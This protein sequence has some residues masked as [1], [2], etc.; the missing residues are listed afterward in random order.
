MQLPEPR[1]GPGVS[2]PDRVQQPWRGRD[3]VDDPKR[4]RIRRHRPEQ[5]LLLTDS[6]E[7]R[8]AFAAVG[9]HHRE[10]ADHPARV[11]TAT[12]L[13]DPSQPR[14]Q[15]R[16]D[17][18]LSAPWAISAL[19][20]RET[21]PAPSDVTSTVTGRPSRITVKV[22]LQR[23]DQGPSASQGSLLSRTFPRPRSSGPRSLLH[24]PG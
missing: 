11:M 14:R 9:Q 22:N 15:R 23:R 20:A 19:P 8:D 4:R 2:Q 1:P 13:L 21:K 16:G 18:T 12:P 24:A 10:V 3:P 17:P 6:T 5:H 7:V